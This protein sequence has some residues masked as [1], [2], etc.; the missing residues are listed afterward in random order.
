LLRR[1]A[2]NGDQSCD[3]KPGMVPALF[4]GPATFGFK[5]QNAGTQ[6]DANIRS[7]RRGYLAA[8]ITDFTVSEAAT[9]RPDTATTCSISFGGEAA[10]ATSSSQAQQRQQL[11]EI[12]EVITIG[13]THICNRKHVPLLEAQLKVR[14]VQRWLI[15][16]EA[17]LQYHRLQ[18]SRLNENEVKQLGPRHPPDEPTLCLID[19]VLLLLGVHTAIDPLPWKKQRQLLRAP[20]LQ[21]LIEFDPTKDDVTQVQVRAAV[22]KWKQVGPVQEDMCAAATTL[23]QWLGAVLWA[24]LELR[25]IASITRQTASTSVQKAIDGNQTKLLEGIMRV[26]GFPAQLI[27]D[28]NRTLAH[29]AVIGLESSGDFIELL[30]DA[31]V[32][33]NALDNTGLNILQHAVLQGNFGLVPVLVEKGAQL[34]VRNSEGHNVL[35]MA[36]NANDLEMAVVLL[37]AK[38]SV[39]AEVPGGKTALDLCGDGEDAA[40]IRDLLMQAGGMTQNDIIESQKV[41][42]PVWED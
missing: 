33:V 32:D 41:P 2:H 28:Q 36:S 7:D 26:D 18:I 40:D 34:D 24:R 25:N 30:L 1:F 35:H 42:E 27:D 16:A 12:R 13:L 29:R 3:L 4:E 21:R 31:G 9:V 22:V 8:E 17:T 23:Y 39:N 19:A 37:R 14:C 10:S 5:R 11:D 15:A 38:A 20:L 6:E